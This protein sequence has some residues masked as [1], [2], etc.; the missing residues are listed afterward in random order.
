MSHVVTQDILVS[1]VSAVTCAAS[2]LGHL[3]IG[4][5]RE[6]VLGVVCSF[7]EVAGSNSDKVTLEQRAKGEETIAKWKS[8]KWSSQPRLVGLCIGETAERLVWLR[9]VSQGE[10]EPGGGHERSSYQ[11]HVKR[12]WTL[13]LIDEKP[14]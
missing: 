7:E 6:L 5:C 13:I 11:M 4:I 10:Q 3:K 9:W 12:V 2:F 8:G 1:F 14:L